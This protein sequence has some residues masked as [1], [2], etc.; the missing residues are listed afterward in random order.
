MKNLLS[1]IFSR[2]LRVPV[3]IFILLFQLTSESRQVTTSFQ[4]FKL[5]EIVLARNMC[6][7]PLNQCEK[8]ITI[9]YYWN[10]FD[11][12]LRARLV[13]WWVHAMKNTNCT[14]LHFYILPVHDR[15]DVSCS[16]DPDWEFRS[17]GV[18]CNKRI[19]LHFL[20]IDTCQK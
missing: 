8:L 18:I 17:I 13:W 7:A 20:L 19:D 6:L 1:V 2:S 16:V 14:E 12:F 10:K 4:F 5:L 15:R 9:S 11:A 3:L